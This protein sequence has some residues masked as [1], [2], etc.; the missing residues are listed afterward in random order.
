LVIQGPNQ[1]SIADMQF[2]RGNSPPAQ[3]GTPVAAAPG[4]YFRVSPRFGGPRAPLPPSDPRVQPVRAAPSAAGPADASWVGQL[5]LANVV[6]ASVHGTDDRD[7]AA[8]QAAAFKVLCD[9]IEMRSGQSEFSLDRMPPG[10]AARFR[11]YK[12][13]RGD[14]QTR[15]KLSSMLEDR[16]ALSAQFRDSV[17]SQHLSAESKSAYDGARKARDQ[18]MEVQRREAARVAAEQEAA[19]AKHQAQRE[20][21]L[22]VA[23]EHA[24]E[25]AAARAAAEKRAAADLKKA[26]D[27]HVDPA[28]FKIFGLALGEPLNLPRCAD[29]QG[30]DATV[31]GALGV[32]K[33]VEKACV[34]SGEN[35]S[36]LSALTGLVG[37]GLPSE[38]QPSWVHSV[39]AVVE[40]GV[41]M[42]L[43]VATVDDRVDD[44]VDHLKH[45]FGH[46]PKPNNK[47]TALEWVRPGL[48]VRYEDRGAWPSGP[49]M[50]GTGLIG[51]LAVGAAQEG[52]A[53]APN[54]FIEMENH[55]KAQ[56]AK[57]DEKKSRDEL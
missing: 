43:A 54:L 15:G 10:A 14:A 6:A 30:T 12:S 24:K 2:A 22:A 35:A 32:H 47:G 40:G 39:N 8:R 27:A 16:Y 52:R 38:K 21:E 31:F 45:K 56:Q 1:L 19:A 4:G 9:Y 37:L 29:F 55:H 41:L 33:A 26:R 7:T 51:A 57:L 13:A 20:A 25:A 34:R 36:V 3:A 17:L 50:V 23:A 46:T 49:T 42:A 53:S 44:Q 18:E 28:I 5:P 48:Y 11:E